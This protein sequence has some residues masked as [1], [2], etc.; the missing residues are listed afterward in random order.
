[1]GVQWSQ[2]QVSLGTWDALGW[3]SLEGSESGFSVRRVLKLVV[4]PIILQQ[5]RA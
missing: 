3:V 5:S 4:Q 2:W 1:M